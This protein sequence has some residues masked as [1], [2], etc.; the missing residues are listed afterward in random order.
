[1]PFDTGI[2]SLHLQRSKRTAGVTKLLGHLVTTLLRGCDPHRG[3]E[4]LGPTAAPAGPGPPGPALGRGQEE[5]G[6]VLCLPTPCSTHQSSAPDPPP[7]LL[8]PSS[9]LWSRP[10]TFPRTC[11]RSHPHLRPLFTQASGPHYET[12]AAHSLPVKLSGSQW[13]PG[14][15]QT[16]VKLRFHLF[17]P[18]RL[19][20]H[21]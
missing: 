4:S 15:V 6:P 18:L 10:P 1:M 3:D 8:P 11:S 20:S 5:A 14:I 16:P 9:G 2:G 17:L 13:F 7:A 21:G 12:P 19:P